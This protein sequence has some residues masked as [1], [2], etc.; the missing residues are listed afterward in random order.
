MGRA[1]WDVQEKTIGHRRWGRKDLWT[2]SYS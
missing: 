1:V 2:K